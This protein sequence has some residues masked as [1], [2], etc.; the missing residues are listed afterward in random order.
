LTPFGDLDGCSGYSMPSSSIHRGAID[1][2]NGRVLGV[3]LQAN[4]GFANMGKM[5]AKTEIEDFDAKN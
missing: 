1:A 4:Q 5:T 3:R 2:Q